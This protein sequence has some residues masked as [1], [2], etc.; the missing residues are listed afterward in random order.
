[1]TPL[2]FKSTTA[3]SPDGTQRLY[4]SLTFR[5]F[6]LPTAA[7]SAALPPTVSQLSST[8]DPETSK[9]T[10]SANVLGDASSNVTDVWITYTSATG[11]RSWNSFALGRVGTSQWTATKSLV[12]L[13]ATAPGDVSLIVQAANAAGLVTLESNAG[14][15]FHVAQPTV[16]AKAPK[17]STAVR[18]TAAPSTSGFGDRR[19]F[20]AIL[21]E[22]VVNDQRPLAGATL[23]FGIGSQRRV[24]T[25]GID[26]TA[27]FTAA[28]D[29][30]P[31]GYTITASF[32]EDAQ[33][34]GSTATALLTVTKAPTAM[35]LTGTASMAYGNR[36]SPVATLTRTPANTPI[37][38]ET[39]FLVA[40]GPNGTFAAVSVTNSAGEAHFAGV[41]PTVGAYTF[42]AYYGQSVPVST[43]TSYDDT[44]P[45]YG[46]S[47]ATG[48]GSIT[49]APLTVKANN[50]T[51]VFS[52]PNPTFAGTLSGVA[53]GDDISATYSTTAVAAS[54]VGAYPITPALADPG[55]KLGNYTVTMTNGTLTVTPLPTNVALADATT[56]YSDGAPLQATVSAVTAGGPVPTG[57]VTFKVGLDTIATATVDAA[58]LATATSAAVT[59]QPGV[60]T[61]LA[62]SFT[63]AS[64][65]FGGSVAGGAKLTVTVEDAVASYTGASV[66]AVNTPLSLGAVVTQTDTSPGD[67]SKA[68]VQFELKLRTS[69]TTLTP[70]GTP[71]PATVDSTGKASASVTLTSANVY[72]IWVTV[73]GAYFTSPP[74]Q[75]YV[76]VYDPSA[77]FV[78][79]GGWLTSPAGAYYANPAATGRAEFGF[80]SKYQKGA[81]VPTGQTQFQFKTGNLNFHADVYDWLVIAGAKAQY[82]GTGTINGA[83]SYKFILTAIDGQWNG[84][85]APDKLRIRIWDLG[86]AVVYDN[87]LGAPDDSDPTTVIGGGN[88]V[89]QKGS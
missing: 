40:T 64:P 11:P 7:S 49:P 6:Y 31:G 86:G 71:I 27:S 21:T 54:S 1:M 77:G 42:H 57:T 37:D 16:T 8:F 36:W 9:V 76:S 32:D 26:G 41:A 89:V 18:F 78:T 70:V 30:T 3:S 85:T 74:V 43:G 28:L 38:G 39:V 52:G 65:N 73:I 88:I 12:D 45:V 58:G 63:S 62:A 61:D 35:T 51:R 2:Q 25:T 10:F 69:P 72:E 14:A 50:A 55:N 84:G 46:P 15:Y 67:I 79:G 22:R 83:G 4:D 68:Q 56:Q 80:V 19:T 13:G 23:T 87:L 34:L 53:V 17:R 5:F 47:D 59:R 44:S 33:H 20:T 66:V 75:T 48:T 82:K 24:V 81:T 60:Y 29:L